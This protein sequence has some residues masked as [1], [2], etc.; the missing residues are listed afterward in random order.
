M[1]GRIS[2]SLY[3]GEEGKGN[4]PAPGPP[5]R[6]LAKC[7]GAQRKKGAFSDSPQSLL[8]AWSEARGFGWE[9]VGPAHPCSWSPPEGWKK[10]NFPEDL[11]SPQGS[12]SLQPQGPLQL[13][14]K[15]VGEEAGRREFPWGLDR[16]EVG[17]EQQTGRQNSLVLIAWL[18][19]CAPAPTGFG[20]SLCLCSMGVGLQSL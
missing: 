15:A 2:P 1:P 11:G 3:D 18:R 5:L 8:T 17:T 13:L 6:L 20:P 7:Y 10:R 14:G 12:K 4:L 9:V 19:S 16:W